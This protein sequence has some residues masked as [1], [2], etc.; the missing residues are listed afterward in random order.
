MAGRELWTFVGSTTDGES[1]PSVSHCITLGV[2][3]TAGTVSSCVHRVRWNKISADWVE[4]F[5]LQESCCFVAG[6]TDKLSVCWVNWMCQRHTADSLPT[7]WF[8]FRK[9]RG[10]CGTRKLPENFETRKLWDYRWGSS[11]DSPNITNIIITFCATI[12]GAHRSG[13]QGQVLI[14]FSRSNYAGVR[15]P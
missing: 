13:R 2:A 3:Q 14:I 10:N 9:R 11:N 6:F 4:R 1:L 5:S 12:A 7:H 8:T 15:V